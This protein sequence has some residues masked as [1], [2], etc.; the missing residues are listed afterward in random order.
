MFKLPI[1]P[2]H[3]TGNN[4]F[5]TVTID[6][7]SIKAVLFY[8]DQVNSSSL[9]I[10]GTGK[11]FLEPNNVRGGVVID[12]D[13]TA[14]KLRL[15]LEQALDGNE[16]E[17]NDV[18]FGVGGSLVNSF[19]TTAKVKRADPAQI[20]SQQEL[21]EVINKITQAATIEAQKIVLQTNGDGEAD[22]ELITSAVV[23]TKVDGTNTK[24]LLTKTG[25]TLEVA[26]FTAFT[27]AYHVKSLQLLA[28]KLK[29]N[30]MA[31]GSEM[32]CIT[33]HLCLS[34]GKNLDCIIV[35]MDNDFTEVGVV[36]GGGIVATKTLDIGSMHLNRAI[37]K[38]TGLQINEAEKMKRTYA[39]GKLTQS[40]SSLVHSC[41]K[42]PINIWLEGIK[43]LFEEFSGVRKFAPMVYLVNEAAELP[44]ILDVLQSEPWE[45][46]I[47]FT[48]PP[49]YTKITLRD[50]NSVT[51]STNTL[52][53]LEFITNSALSIVYLEMKGLLNV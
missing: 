18:I 16:D 27:H 3:T 44:D 36:F 38:E 35:N 1:K 2:A 19:V 4:K 13:Q 45:R 41:I 48:A 10:I 52:G 47:S 6:S 12:P 51:D 33:K 7:D 8:H 32:Y 5:F 34:K 21:N 30:I 50:L 46:S 14:E 49:S 20:I 17:D 11:Q 39:Y 43:L 24:E 40:E 26:L 25:D 23:Y 9:K 15:V 37:S 28:K 53:S 42:N 31:I 29:L 22:L